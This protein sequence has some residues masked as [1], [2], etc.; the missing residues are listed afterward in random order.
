MKR[1]KISQINVVKCNV[2]QN[3]RFGEYIASS[4]LTDLFNN[5]KRLK[6]VN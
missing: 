3:Y 6:N 5:H 4:K 1:S 2:F